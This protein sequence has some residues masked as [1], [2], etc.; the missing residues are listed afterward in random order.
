MSDTTTQESFE[1]AVVTAIDS[2]RVLLQ[3]GWDRQ[4]L[5]KVM[6]DVMRRRIPLDEMVVA[7]KHLMSIAHDPTDPALQAGFRLG[8]KI[9]ERDRFVNA[10]DLQDLFEEQGGREWEGRANERTIKRLLTEA[11]GSDGNTPAI[12]C[13]VV[14]HGYPYPISGAL[15]ESQDGG[16]RLMAPDAGASTMIEHFFGYED[17]VAVVVRRPISVET[18]RI[19]TS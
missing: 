8:T 1:A 6:T 3:S 11:G 19:V 9:A 5:T 7:I 13:A 12:E 10:D 2:A 18:A 15:S 16:V 17:I 4:A 14:L